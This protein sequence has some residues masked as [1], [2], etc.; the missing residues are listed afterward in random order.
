MFFF[1]LLKCFKISVNKKQT[2]VAINDVN[3]ISNLSSVNDN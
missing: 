1:K 3:T 2:N